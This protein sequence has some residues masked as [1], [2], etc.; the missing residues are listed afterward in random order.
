MSGGRLSKNEPSAMDTGEELRSD[1]ACRDRTGEKYPLTAAALVAG[2]TA[3]RD[4]SSSTTGPLLSLERGEAGGGIG[5]A[6]GAEAAGVVGAPTLWATS[7]GAGTES[8]GAPADAVWPVARDTK[9]GSRGLLVHSLTGLIRWATL[10]S[11]LLLMR[12]QLSTKWYHLFT[13]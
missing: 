11:V 7:A 1:M 12:R 9:M 5:I 3:Y 2:R 13:Q 6:A 4:G 10:N 8:A